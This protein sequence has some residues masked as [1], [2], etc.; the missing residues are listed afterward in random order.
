MSD[1]EGLSRRG[2]GRAVL[3]GVASAA[4]AMPAAASGAVVD[5]V[6]RDAALRGLALSVHRGD[7]VSA[8]LAEQAIARL[9][10]TDAEGALLARLYR[11]LDVR[12]AGDFWRA[13]GPADAGVLALLHQ[14]VGEA[15][16]VSFAY[17]DLEDRETRRSVL[18]LALVH[19]P[20]GVKLLAWCQ[21]RGDYR[22]FF[23]REMGDVAMGADGFAEARMTLLQGLVEKER[24]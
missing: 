14:A 13:H 12:P 9:A 20:Q 23:V 17:R 5:P 16:S 7:P 15:R 4:V 10:H 19:P 21:L 6:L 1:E 2:F 18:P 8:R 3:T 11:A 22:Q 24:A